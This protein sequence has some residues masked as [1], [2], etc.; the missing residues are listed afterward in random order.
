MF[1][2]PIKVF[3]AIAATVFWNIDEKSFDK[4]PAVELG[5]SA[6]SMMHRSLA[7]LTK[8]PFSV[9]PMPTP[10]RRWA[11]NIIF[12]MEEANYEEILKL[13]KDRRKKNKGKFRTGSQAWKI[14]Q[15]LLPC[16]RLGNKRGSAGAKMS[17]FRQTPCGGGRKGQTDDD[18]RQGKSADGFKA[19]LFLSGSWS[20]F[21][22]WALKP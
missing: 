16:L 9:T 15:D 17:C 12:E 13:L 18:K 19:A 20:S 1:S 22:K 4:I 2:L 5:L 14:S 3:M 10:C 7:S 6:D 8:K 11:E 21:P